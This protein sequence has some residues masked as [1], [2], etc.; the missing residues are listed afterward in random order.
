MNYAPVTQY[1]ISAAVLLFNL[2]TC[3]SVQYQ[4]CN[5]TLTSTESRHMIYVLVTQ[6]SIS[7]AVLP[8]L[9]GMYA[10]LSTVSV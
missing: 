4:Y 5:T 3:F 10:L 1:T 6:Y 8:T 9:F 2:C 7:A